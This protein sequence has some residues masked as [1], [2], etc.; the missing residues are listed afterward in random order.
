MGP[1]DRVDFAQ[2][3]VRIQEPSQKNLNYL[4]R[5]NQVLRGR[6]VEWTVL[7]SN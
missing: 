2:D 4:S 3:H 1:L 6:T 7:I 5:L